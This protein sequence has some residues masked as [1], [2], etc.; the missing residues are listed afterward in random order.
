MS[1]LS[2]LILY[3]AFLLAIIIIGEITGFIT[4]NLYVYAR[5]VVEEMPR[6]TQFFGDYLFSSN[7]GSI[8]MIMLIPYTVYVFKTISDYYLKK[9]SISSILVSTI[10][11][12]LCELIILSIVYFA[13]A[14]PFMPI[15]E[16]LVEAKLHFYY[17]HILLMLVFVCMSALTCVR[18]YLKRYKESK[19]D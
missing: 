13:I 4:F 11:L 9:S 14:I 10:L 7:N 6:L 8:S 18:I 19:N 15:Y 1:K 17:P 5:N 16:I 12:F 3:F 2:V